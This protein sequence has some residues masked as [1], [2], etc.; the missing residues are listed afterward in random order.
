MAADIESARRIIG[1][2]EVYVDDTIVDKAGSLI[3]EGADLRLKRK[4]PYVSRGGEKLAHSLKHFAVS[5]AGRNCL[6]VGASTGGFTDC[7]L[8]NGAE[9]V[10][11][12]D[13]GYGDLAWKLRQDERVVVMERCNARRLPAD[14]F[15]GKEI[16]LAVTDVSFISLT[17]ILPVLF[18]ACRASKKRS[19]I[20]ALIKPQFELPKEDVAGGVVLSPFL[21]QKAIDAVL[22]FV[23]GFEE[24]SVDGVVQSPLYGAKGNTEFLLHLTL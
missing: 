23:A 10:Y 1:A 14:T 17:K 2:G 18:A 9:R 24:I 7:L 11:A 6:D 20:I 3:A 21:H 5:P 15:A 19:D 4:L 22:S 16:S 8:Q 12:V 13:V